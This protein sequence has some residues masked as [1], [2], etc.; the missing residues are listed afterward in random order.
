MRQKVKVLVCGGPGSFK[1]TILNIIH[2]ALVDAG[3]QKLTVIETEAH[4]D[5]SAEMAEA[6]LKALRDSPPEVTIQA[7]QANRRGELHIKKGKL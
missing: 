7:V 6:R 5:L 2:D 4:A 1:S 3:V